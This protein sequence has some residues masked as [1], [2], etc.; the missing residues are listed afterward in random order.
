MDA[1]CSIEGLTVLSFSVTR[2]ALMFSI[3]VYV[4]LQEPGGLL[5]HPWV[6][7]AGDGAVIV[8]DLLT[9]RV[10]HEFSTGG[11]QEESSW[12]RWWR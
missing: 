6:Q 11:N 4:L 5:A 1:T 3:L 2:T 7:A 9:A 10:V 12:W 8:R